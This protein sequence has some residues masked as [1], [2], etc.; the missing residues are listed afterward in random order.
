MRLMEKKMQSQIERVCQTGREAE[1]QS[2]RARPHEM[3]VL[4]KK[5]SYPGH[6]RFFQ[7]D[8]DEEVDDEEEKVEEETTK[9][10]KYVP[11]KVMAVH[12]DGLFLRVSDSVLGFLARTIR[13]SPYRARSCTR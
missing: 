11:P 1:K 10:K 8:D 9:S 13:I 5:N 12:Y 3:Q 6:C 4:T 2:L 7:L